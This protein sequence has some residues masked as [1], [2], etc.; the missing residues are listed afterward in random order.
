MR[1]IATPLT[2]RPRKCAS[3]GRRINDEHFAGANSQED[4]SA[5][6]G[7]CFVGFRTPASLGRVE[8]N[9]GRVQLGASVLASWSDIAHP[10]YRRRKHSFTVTAWL[11][12]NPNTAGVEAYRQ[13]RAMSCPLSH[14][15]L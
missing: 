3:I 8:S 2:Y 4:G 9:R 6:R 1:L 5:L 7:T 11:G 12:R 15:G 13:A 14:F 10:R